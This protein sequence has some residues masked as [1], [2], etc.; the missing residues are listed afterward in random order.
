MQILEENITEHVPAEDQEE[1]RSLI[2]QTI[3]YFHDAWIK[4]LN[5]CGFYLVWST[6]TSATPNDID[7]VL[8]GL[9]F[10]K[11]FSYDGVFLWDPAALV[12]HN[13]VVPLDHQGAY[14]WP[15]LW[16]TVCLEGKEYAYNTWTLSWKY[17]DTVK[18]N[19]RSCSELSPFVA[20]LFLKLGSDTSPLDYD[21]LHP[22]ACEDDKYIVVQCMVG[23]MINFIIHAENLLVESWKRH[24]E[25]AG[26]VFVALCEWPSVEIE[27][28]VNR[29]WFW[30]IEYPDFIDW[31]GKERAGGY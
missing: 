18:T 23:K 1:V 3:D 16:N 5:V 31:K 8:V 28:V 4:A 2:Q 13:V 22:Y 7:V 27:A 26:K 19:C 20:D 6:L 30:G 10:R 12:E 9:D 29:P 11:I 21:P 25:E 17:Y 14:S 15:N 24:Q